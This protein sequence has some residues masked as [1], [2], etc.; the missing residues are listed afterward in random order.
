MNGADEFAR[1]RKSLGTDGDLNYLF[2][3]HSNDIGLGRVY[4]DTEGYDG[5]C[6]AVIAF[7]DARVRWIDEQMA[8]Q[9]TLP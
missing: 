7:Y 9:T 3:G 4:G 6:D 5:L 2:Y 8:L 1:Q